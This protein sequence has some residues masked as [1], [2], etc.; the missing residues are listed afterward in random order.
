VVL[1]ALRQLTVLGIV[2]AV[3]GGFIPGFGIADFP[4]QVF[5]VE[6]RLIEFFA[7]GGRP[8]FS[9]THDKCERTTALEAIL[10]V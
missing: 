2:V 10:A 7:G 8:C 9:I 5:G 6:R 4:L 3:L 1:P